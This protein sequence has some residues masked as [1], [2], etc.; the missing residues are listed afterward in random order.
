M[1]TI[2]AIQTLDVA[3]PTETGALARVYGA[4]HEAKINVVASWG[5]EMAPGK[6][7]AHFYVTDL[8]ATRDVLTRMGF[9]ATTSNAVWFEGKDQIGGY[10]ELLSKVAKANVN[11]TATDAIAIGG[12]FASVLFTAPADFAKLR[13]ALK[14]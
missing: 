14:I 12:N 9:T 2:K 7:A 3:L 10:A 6:A 4:F 8:E 13:T 11:L 5:Y 1:G